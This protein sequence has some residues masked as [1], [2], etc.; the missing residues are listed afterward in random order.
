MLVASFCV[1]NVTR[2]MIVMIREELLLSCL[3]ALLRMQL[4][5]FGGDTTFV[6]FRFTRLLPPD[7]IKANKI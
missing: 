5:L 3:D 2:S 1:V 6:E 7:T 4:L